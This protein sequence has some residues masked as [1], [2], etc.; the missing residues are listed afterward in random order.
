M[1]LARQ[2]PKEV[3]HDRKPA[4]LAPP[5]RRDIP[6]RELIPGDLVHLAVGDRVPADCRVLDARDLF[7]ALAALPGESLQASPNSASSADWMSA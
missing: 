4:R 3:E 7:I 5:Q 1:R 2:G 6:L